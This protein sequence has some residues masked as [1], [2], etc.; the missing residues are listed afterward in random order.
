[1]GQS[2]RFAFMEYFSNS[3]VDITLL[4]KAE[5][6]S[7]QPI[8]KNYWKIMKWS[9]MITWSIVLIIGIMLFAFIP[10]V[11]SV[12]STL[13]IIPAFAI[14]FLSFWLIKKSFAQKGFV[15]REKDLLYK[16]GWLIQSISAIP[17][18]RIQHCSV[19]SGILERTQGLASLS[20]FTAGTAGSDLKIPGLKTAA[21]N[22]M[23][24]FIMTKI[25]TDEQSGN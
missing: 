9:W 24:D 5:D 18:N 17:F 22:E 21:A 10:G 2:G 1:M 25:K 8:E 15:V 14:C 23:R 6:I 7:F 3:Q 16:S 4:P 12:R 13:F 20:I 11:R 19:S